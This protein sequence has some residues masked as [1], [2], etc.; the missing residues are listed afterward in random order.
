MKNILFAFIILSTS[1]TNSLFAKLPGIKGSIKNAQNTPVEFANVVLVMANDSA[2]VKAGLTE[3]DGTYL[4]ENIPLGQ[5]KLLVVQLGYQKFYSEAFEVKESPQPIIL[6]EVVLEESAI[7]LKEATIT[8]KKPLIEHHIDK[9]VVNVEN[10]VVNAGATAIEILKRSPGVIVDNEGNIGL[11]GKSGVNV[12]IDGKPTYLSA[13][14]LYEMLKNMNSDQLSRIDI[15]TNPSAKYDAAGNSG[16]I[17]IRLRKR[18]DVG[19]NGSING[20]Y[21]QGSYPDASGGINLNYRKEKF[22]LFGGYD[23]TKGYYNTKTKLS[24]RFFSDGSNT[25]FD[26]STFNKGNYTNQNFKGG[27][28]YYIGKKHSFSAVLRGNF[29]SNYDSTTSTTLIKNTS[30]IVDSSYITDNINNSKWNSLTGTLNYQ[31]KIDSLGRELTVDFDKAKYDNGNDFVFRTNYYDYNNTV[32]KTEYATNDQPATIDINSVKLDYT[33]PW[34]KTMKID[35]G[36]KSS[37]VTTDNDVRYVNYYGNEAVLDTGK[38]NH[39][40]YKENINAAYINWTGEHKKV[41]FEI[42]L[43]G[44]QTIADGEQ[45]VNNETF[46]RNYFQLFPSAFLNYKFTEKHMTRLSYSRRIDRP[47][48]QQLNPF[49]YFL[50]PYTYQQGNPNLQPQITDN[51]EASYTF[52]QLYTITFNFSHTSDA[53][54][55]ITK[56]NDST[57]TTF[58]TTENLNSK[59]NYGVNINL[60][61]HVT[62]WWT[63]SNNISIFNNTYQ[64]VSSVGNIDQSLTSYFINSVNSLEMKKGWSFEVSGYYQSKMVWGTWLVNPQ[65]SV[66]AGI[67]KMLLNDRLQ[68]RVNLNDIFFTQQENSTIKYQNI[69]ATFSQMYDSQFVRFHVSYS[70]GKRNIKTKNHSRG[71]EEENRINSGR[72]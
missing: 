32:V 51:Y 48:Y 22:N 55:Q 56:Q 53:M 14:D 30:E 26:Q 24:R 58:I 50:D 12:M 18:Q 47:G 17:D 46:S 54:T 37:F 5:Y 52:K 13:K 25:L 16:I 1:F 34:K 2:I 63:S 61:I 59:D 49:R 42:G 68:I 66:S 72:Q 21:G 69:D 36:L 9:T 10:S 67:S 31:F 28:D 41:G 35:A 57:H 43:R 7:N 33:Q 27:I 60:P 64:G 20:S 19:L 62:E 38:T 3:T 70:F 44:E 11:S 65:W 4:F 6:K 29:N 39:F 23:Y 8:A 71:P 15:I 40:N 45:V